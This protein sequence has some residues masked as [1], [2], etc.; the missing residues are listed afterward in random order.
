[1]KPFI[2]VL[3]CCVV[4]SAFAQDSVKK[5]TPVPAAVAAPAKTYSKYKTP[6]QPGNPAAGSAVTQQAT[7]IQQVLTDKSLNGRYQ[8]LLA[9]IYRYQQPPVAD[10]WKNASDTLNLTKHKLSDANASLSAQKKTIDSLNAKLSGKDESV[11]DTNAKI[12][13]ISMFGVLIPKSA[14]NLVMWGLVLVLAI[15]VFIIITRSGSLKHEA[16]YR[17]KLY[18]ELED[19]FKAYKTKANDKEKKLAR[20]LQTERNKLD[21]L[22]GRG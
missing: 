22:L 7:A 20:E 10:F 3:I 13:D 18:T 8:F 1:M 2:I 17:T 11:S 5:A 15:T 14:Y 16:K 4:S 9:H 12:D 19:E 21:E 6:P